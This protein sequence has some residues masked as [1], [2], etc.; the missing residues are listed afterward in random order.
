MIAKPDDI[1]KCPSIRKI[2]KALASQGQVLETKFFL[3]LSYVGY[4][5]LKIPLILPHIQG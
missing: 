2:K 5:H 1:E 4:L 3:S